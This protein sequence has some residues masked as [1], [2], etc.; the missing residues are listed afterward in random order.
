[1]PEFK[2]GDRWVGDGHPAYFIADISA[3]HDGQLQRA[4]ELIRLAKAAGA[5]GAKFQHF[6]AP[7]IVS[8]QGFEGMKSQLSHQASWKKSVYQVYEEASLPWEWTQKLK[9]CCQEVG[10]DFFSAPY[11]LEAVEM[12]AAHVPVWKIGSGDVTWSEILE[13]IASQG[14]PVF[15]ATGA[16]TMEEVERAVGVIL[17]HNR[18]LAV[19]QCNTNYTGRDE[20][21]DHI[22]LNVLKSYRAAFPQAVL[23]LSDHTRG[24]A[25]VL[26]A[27]A[28][29]ARVIEKH[30]TD[31]SG[32]EGPD[33]PF[34]ATPSEWR[35]MVS[36]TRELERAL[37]SDR[38]MVSGNEQ[39]T[40]V[41]QRRCLRAARDLA[42]GEKLRREDIE[43]LRPSPQEAIQ[44][45]E[46]ERAIGRVLKGPVREG[47]PLTWDKL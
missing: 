3:N 19:M 9:A 30:F 28:L 24:L 45:H 32:R 2:V 6:R 13:K 20:N 27:V 29:G 14:Q 23:G 15:L 16:S 47:D 26:G 34:S 38:K 40:V 46:L 37:G 7:K 42:A 5:D 44:P 41:L 25:T 39:E 35:E 4:L 10:I 11:D 31:D 8:H 1:M 33:H 21:F 12:L 17:R 18:N 36:R 22:H 43:V